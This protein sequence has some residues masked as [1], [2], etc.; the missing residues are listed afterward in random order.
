MKDEVGVDSAKQKRKLVE[1]EVGVITDSVGK[2][3]HGDE[4]TQSQVI[5]AG[6][7]Y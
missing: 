1:V 4:K 3:E 5:Q 6:I 7:L 2:S